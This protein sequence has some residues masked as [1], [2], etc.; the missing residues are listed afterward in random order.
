VQPDSI[1]PDFGN[2]LDWDRYT[3]A[4][5]NPVLYN[6][7]TGHMACWDEHAN[8]PGCEGYIPTG[9]GLIPKT[10][11]GGD[12]NQLIKDRGISP[13]TDP[14]FDATLGGN[15]RIDKSENEPPDNRLSVTDLIAIGVPLTSAIVLVEAGLT[16]AEIQIA[17]VTLAAPESAIVTIPLELVLTNSSLALIDIDIAYW[18]YTYRVAFAP[19]GEPVR[20]EILPLWGF[21]N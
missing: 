6:D 11:N 16:V 13:D 12:S 18:S 21:E 9:N 7:P 2:P 15:N 14:S 17:L 3:Y 1:V 5:N 20:F 4:R 10:A 19:H 8:D